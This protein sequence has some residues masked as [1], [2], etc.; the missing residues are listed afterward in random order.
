[1][2]QSEPGRITSA[3]P[4]SGR[5]K[6]KSHGVTSLQHI[7]LGLRPENDPGPVEEHNA[8][9]VIGDFQPAG[10]DRRRGRR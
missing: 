5:A 4:H 9:A 2:S 7:A 1:M 6:P 3:A 8:V 10:S